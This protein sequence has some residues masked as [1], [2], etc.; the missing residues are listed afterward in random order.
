MRRLFVDTSAWF[1]YCNRS[2][3]QHAA[4]A[5][6]LRTFEGRLLTSNYVFDEIVTLS[7]RRLGHAAALLVG[8]V[9]L[10]VKTVDVLRL[11][12]RDEGDAWELFRRRSDKSYS[13]TDCTSFVLLRRLGLMEALAFDD[14]FQQEG[15]LPVL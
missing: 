10:D 14:H 13:F 15:F 3:P 11:T 4:V 2:E 1:A 5:A 6:F 12:P 7:R 9:L 8:A